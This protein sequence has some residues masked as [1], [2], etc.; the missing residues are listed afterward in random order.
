MKRLALLSLLV[1]CSP[2]VPTRACSKPTDCFSQEVCVEKQCVTARGE[3]VEGDAEPADGAPLPD[4]A[5]PESDD[6]G[7]DA[8]P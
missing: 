8:A 2:E 3:P 5:P 1:G 6:A 7:A 4:V